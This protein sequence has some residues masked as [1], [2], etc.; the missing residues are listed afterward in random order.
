MQLLPVEIKGIGHSVPARFFDN[1]FL[2]EKLAVTEEWIYSRTGIRKRHIC[3]DFQTTSDLALEASL[4]SINNARI[5]PAEINMIVFCTLT[6]DKLCPSTASRLQ[7]L[8]GAVNAFCFDLNAACSGFIYGLSVAYNYIASGSCENVLVVGADLLSRYTD[9]QDR[10]TAILFGDA[11]GAVVVGKGTENAFLSFVLGADGKMGNCIQI[12]GSG[13]EKSNLNPY[14]IMKGSEVFKWAVNI[15]PEAITQ[16]VKK[17]G[18]EISQIDH[19]VFHQANQRITKAIINKLKID[20]NKV[21]SN[22]SDYGN[23]SA[24]SIPLLLSELDKKAIIAKNQKILLAGFGG[25]LTW[26]S[27]VIEWKK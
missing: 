23:T 6:P 21:H 27:C 22:I 3:E 16:S 18:L 14:F 8:L 20:E 5:S 25:G 12:P 26:G 1:R 4:N 9:Y 7:G 13:A 17:A 11:A 19:F 2:A 15:A 24:A 10:T